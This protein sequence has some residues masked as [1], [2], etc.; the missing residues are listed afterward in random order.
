MNNNFTFLSDSQ[1]NGSPSSQLDILKKCD[2]TAAV[3]D[4]SIFLGATVSHTIFTKGSN[5][6]DLSERT[7]D[8]W[9]GNKRLNSDD[10]IYYIDYDGDRMFNDTD[11]RYIGA[12]PAIAFSEI[13]K[14]V[15]KT[16]I[17]KFG[18]KIVEYGEY[19]Q[20]VVS[21]SLSDE[22]EEEFTSGNL[23]TTGK[24]YTT[25]SNNWDDFG[26]DFSP[27]EHEEYEYKGK[28]YIRVVG[29]YNC[30]ETKLSDGREIVDGE[31]YWIKVEPIEWLVDEKTD[32]ALSKKI[33]F[34]GV[35]FTFGNYDGNFLHSGIKNFMDQYFSKDIVQNNANNYSNNNSLDIDNMK[36]TL[37]KRDSVFTSNRSKIFDSYDVYTNCTSLATLLGCARDSWG[38]ADYWL[39]TPKN[40][41]N[42]CVVNSQGVDSF[43]SVGRSNIGI[44]PAVP[45]ALIRPLARNKS[46]LTPDV[47]TVECGEYPQE[48]A[49]EEFTN[50]L[51][52]L[53]LSGD[54]AKTGKT[55]TFIRKENKDSNNFIPHIY[56][57]YVYRGK[58]YIRIKHIN[59]PIELAEDNDL[60]FPDHRTINTG[61]FV[62]FEVS[63]VTWIVDRERNS[64]VSERI[65]LSGMRYDDPRR[66]YGDFSKTELGGYLDKYMKFDIFKSTDQL[67]VNNS[68]D[69]NLIQ[70]FIPDEE[71]EE[72]LP[73]A[74]KENP[75]GFN[76]DEVSEEDIIRGA[77]ESNVS[78]F[79]HGRSSEG[80]S[81]RVKELDPDCEI[82]YMRNA[83]PDSLNGK[84]VYNSETGE[85]I[86]VPP[87]WYTKIKNK[88][89]AEPDKIHIVF[90]DELT[91]AL[92][93]I[94][95]MAFNIVLD[96]EV[97][98]K[99]KLP[100][101]AR[102]VA[103]GNDLNDSLAANQMAEPL[104]NR[105]AHVYIETDVDSWLKWASTPAEDYQRI[106]YKGEE[107]LPKIHPAIYAYVAYKSYSGDDVL[108][109]E[110]TGDKPNADPRK[111]EMAS[112]VLYKT[113][114]PEMLRALVGEEITYDFVEFTKQQVITIDDV[115]SNNYNNADL[116][117]D[118]AQKFA[119]AVGLSSVS[120]EHVEVVRNFMKKLGAEPRA[121]FE[122]MWTHGDK[123]R[124]ELLAE[125][126]LKD[127]EVYGGLSI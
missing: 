120:E 96:G 31:A 116:E 18:V 93:S 12:R 9:L 114:K 56:S 3:T 43:E 61:D 94:Q 75:Y 38:D 1:V 36:M 17:G 2:V 88:C 115:L 21:G 112:K 73:K 19:P 68:T 70:D 24:T 47:F 33:I 66:Y 81:A 34:S 102:I 126:Q 79:L 26:I 97:N 23:R 123:K 27:M 71:A 63:P 72:E 101:N 85:M 55:Y 57:E 108:R 58:K 65:L 100:P 82:I 90:F 10:E 32:I 92:P 127:E 51:E 50:E 74:R 119:T 60:P 30:E 80:K 22:L 84:S 77:V 124:L 125:L 62:W 105:F 67:Q 39:S 53:F 4:F 91:N 45:Y 121:A 41:D 13:R 106:D 103:A 64:A 42:A 7:G 87:T 6:T 109:T 98:G 46:M 54:L 104:F 107:S 29:N 113:K 59:A 52:S 44:R 111:W 35:Q 110:Y 95:G 86:D 16:K 48:L 15:S 28:K 37:L 83:T 8:W 122:S 118:T 14:D 49:S 5:S 99:W 89:D 11:T 69:D 20:T 117:M 40:V 25:D 76:F 78:V